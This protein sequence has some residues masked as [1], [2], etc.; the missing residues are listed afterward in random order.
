MA[1]KYKHT[2]VETKWQERW[3][4]AKLYV[5]DIKSGKNPFYNLWMYPYPSAE[6]LHAGHAFASTGSDVAGRF[7]RMQGRE[8]FQPIGYDSFGIHSENYALK[9]NE[10]PH[11][12][13]KRTTKHYEAQLRSLGHGYDWTR[14]VT[15]SEVG[16]YKWTQW[17]FRELF[18]AGLA[19][20]KKAEVNFC[21]HDK[22]VLADEQVMTPK[23][24]GKE[25]I[26]AEGNPVPDSPEIRVCER[27]GTVVE[28]RELE[29]WFFRITDYADKLLENLKK[30]DW[31]EKVKIAQHEWIGKSHGMIINFKKDDGSII[32]VFTTRPDTL[33][34]VT[35]IAE[36]DEN[37]YN[38]GESEKIGSST[39]QYALSPLD[40][41][42][43][44]IW[45]T[46]Y[47]APGYGTG[48]VMG[49]PAHDE[50]DMEFAKKYHLD[51][52][53]KDPDD[54]L[55][56]IIEDNGW[57]YLHTNYHLRDWLISRQRYWGPPI[58]MIYCEHC[59][60][61][62]EGWIGSNTNK[63]IHRSHE[64]WNWQG[65]WP[66]EDLP[67]ELP[68]IKDWKPAGNG[69]GPLAAHPEFFTVKCP[70]CG[71][72]A[73]R[74]TDVS[75]TFLDSAWY[76]LRYPTVGSSKAGLMPFDKDITSKWLPV[77]LYF[78]GAEHSV[79]HLMYARFVT[80]VLNDLKYLDFDEPF[81]KFFAHGLM[82]KDGAKMSKSRG[83]VVNPDEYIKKFGTD[84]FRLY[85]MFIGPMDSSP[86]FRDTG[87]EG[88]VRFVNRIWKLYTDYKNFAI[89]DEKDAAE[90]LSKLHQTIKKVTEDMEVF[91]Y[92][93]AIAGIMEFVNVL[94][95]K[96]SANS[97]PGVANRQT[98]VSCAE[99]DESLLSLVQMLAPFAPH[100]SEEIWVE[101]LGKPFSIHKSD[102]PKYNANLIKTEQTNIIVQVNGKYRGQV[103]IESSDIKDEDKIT[104]IAKKDEKVAKWLTGKI[105][106]SI[107]VPGK[108]LNFVI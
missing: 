54:K 40:G 34:A 49:V 77:N 10:N 72:G 95:E 4:N 62:G 36:S 56:K 58:P 67:V 51:I 74:E 80:Q 55:W 60:K 102:W 82:I 21:P 98:K 26:N 30:I 57:G 92:N 2:L 18:E 19:Y 12:V 16:Y 35:F 68:N 89:E 97:A 70:H 47:V 15:V 53:Q 108:L 31:T 81:T 32:S 76:F 73:V 11:E 38:R 48:A 20:R 90:V 33:N 100:I 17:L 9:I 105:K 24:A 59:A 64:D 94:Y 39:N 71:L 22:T 44:P 27:C 69:R 25:P 6:G 41:R 99:W 66:E 45:K 63:L 88:M 86:D 93:T 3:E 50:R 85:V 91:K 103:T 84:A 104:E 107:Y 101:I 96:I 37:L 28:K 23:Q 1:D 75:D 106:K 87:I 79:L 65:W 42:K 61:K 14:T 5:A 43:I 29:Q 52:V 78:G 8:V 7:M 83:N 13:I 46:N